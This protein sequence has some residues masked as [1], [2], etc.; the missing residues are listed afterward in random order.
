MSIVRPPIFALLF[1][2]PHAHTGYVV[3]GS[4]S[5]RHALVLKCNRCGYAR[6]VPAPERKA[7]DR[8]GRWDIDHGEVGAEAVVVAEKEEN[9]ANHTTVSN[10]EEHQKPTKK[11]GKKRVYPPLPLSARR[12]AGHVVFR[13]NEK[14][15]IGMEEIN[16]VGDGVFAV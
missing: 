16:E 6:R 8:R 13:G 5:H 9:P 3:L 1:P 11:R 10:K 12:D 7:W 15:E 4:L 14:L 2:C